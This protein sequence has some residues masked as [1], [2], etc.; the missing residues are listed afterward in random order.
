VGVIYALGVI[1]HHRNRLYLVLCGAIAIV[2]ASVTFLRAQTWGTEESLI[3][4]MGRN[5]PASP[6]TQALLAEYYAHRLGNLVEAQRHYEIA[7]TLKPDD[8]SYTIQMLIN[9]ARISSGVNV[10]NEKNAGA[11]ALETSGKISITPQLHD[12]IEEY[13]SSKPLAPSILFTL[14]HLASC[15]LQAPSECY[16]LYPLA[17]E[18]YRGA[19]NNPRISRNAKISISIY[20]FRIYMAR[21]DDSAALEVAINAR[22]FDPTDISLLLMEADAR[23]AL[24]QFGQAEEMLLHASDGSVTLPPE[25]VHGINVLLARIRAIRASGAAR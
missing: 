17:I 13:L 23:I 14:D 19:L 21:S 4:T 24:H 25:A 9:T 10:V 22:S 5:H 1:F 16:E 12:H 3:T 7:I 6:R 11:N 15:I 2:L 8:I 18:W 20:L